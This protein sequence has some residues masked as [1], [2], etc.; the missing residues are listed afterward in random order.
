MFPGWQSENKREQTSPEKQRGATTRNRLREI[1]AENILSFKLI[2][3][4]FCFR[5]SLLSFAPP[6]VNLSA[7]LFFIPLFGDTKQIETNYL[8]FRLSTLTT[9]QIKRN[10]GELFCSSADTK[11]SA[12]GEVTANICWSWFSLNELFV[13]DSNGF[14]S[15]W[16]FVGAQTPAALKS[17]AKTDDLSTSP[18]C[19]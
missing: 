7:L 11:T 2:N 12:R 4:A 17:V 13:I 5:L 16:W 8:T 19:R 6:Y 15:S 18:I 10:Y 9:A 1:K 3:S 14:T